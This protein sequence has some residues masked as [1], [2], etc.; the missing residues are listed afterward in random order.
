MRLHRPVPRLPKHTVTKSTGCEEQLIEFLFFCFCKEEDRKTYH[1][2]VS[3][4]FPPEPCVG[5][6]FVG[7]LAGAGTEGGMGEGSRAASLGW[8]ALTRTVWGI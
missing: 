8:L 5:Q 7:G 3:L 4:S 2:F 1:T 6:G